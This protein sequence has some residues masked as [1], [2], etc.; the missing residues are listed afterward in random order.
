[1]SSLDGSQVAVAARHSTARLAVRARSLAALLLVGI[2]SGYFAS[3]AARPLVAPDEFRYAEIP[4]EMLASGDWLVPRLDGL[5]YFEKPPLGFWVTAASIQTF[6]AHRAAVRLPSLV[7]TLL[8]A[9]IAFVLV[10]RFG[11]GEST[12]RFTAL[13]LLSCV[14]VA[15]SGSAAVLDALFALGVAATLAA[16]FVASEH[17]PGSARQR[18]LV[19]C[20]AACGAAFLTKGLLAFAIPIAVAVPYFVWSRRSRELLRLP[21]TPLAVALIVA[22]PWA[23]AIAHSEPDFWPRFIWNEH[24]RRFAGADAQHPEPFWFFV[25][26]VAGG[27]TP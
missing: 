9:A 26:V 24:L 23:I 22:T 10:R 12:A 3:I 25:P 13:G 14:E 20:G 1:M 5:L 6:G 27:A 18:W 11:A 2:A 4:R 21:W 8:T 19:A 17:P 7:A 16:L 15:V